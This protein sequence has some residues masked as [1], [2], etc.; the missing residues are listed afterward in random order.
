MGTASGHHTLSATERE[1]ERESRRGAS[2]HLSIS[3]LQVLFISLFFI[4]LFTQI[5]FPSISL[6]FKLCT[7]QCESRL[8]LWK[9]KRGDN[10]GPNPQI[11]LFVFRL[12]KLLLS[13]FIYCTITVQ[14]MPV[15]VHV[16]IL[17]T[18]GF[19]VLQVPLC[20]CH[21]F[22]LHYTNRTDDANQFLQH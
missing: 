6:L 5:V 4:L 17:F 3:P 21:N 2:C 15:L 7:A 1:R 19:C 10:V 22:S 13:V 20:S 11:S 18:T 9:L 12:S 14:F 8:L 16:K